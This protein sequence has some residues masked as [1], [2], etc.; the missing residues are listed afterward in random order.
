MREHSLTVKELRKRLADYPDDLEVWLTVWVPHNTKWYLGGYNRS[1]PID[2]IYV[3]RFSDYKGMSDE[4]RLSAEPEGCGGSIV[5]DE[6]PAL[7]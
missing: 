2:N 3:I 7:T 4:L 1:A 6:A 5:N